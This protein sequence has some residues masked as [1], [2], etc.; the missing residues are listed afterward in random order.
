[1]CANRKI[2]NHIRH[3]I[4]HEQ[5]GLDP[6][7]NQFNCTSLAEQCAWDLDHD[8]WLDDDT[9]IVWDIAVDEAQRAEREMS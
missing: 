2:R 3:L 6:L 5:H 4:I 8:E 7:T 9:H 1:M